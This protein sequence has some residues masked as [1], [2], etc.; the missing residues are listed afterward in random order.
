M[1]PESVKEGFL[2]ISSQALTEKREE[3]E[4]KWCRK[5][6]ENRRKVEETWGEQT[7]RESRWSKRQAKH[8]G[9][10]KTGSLRTKREERSPSCRRR[11]SYVP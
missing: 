3:K 5:S 4:R 11:K 10:D 9:F 8:S 7:R 1:V 2:T 6:G